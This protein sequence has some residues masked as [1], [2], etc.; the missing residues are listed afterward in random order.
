MA[1]DFSTIKAITIPEGTVKKI[2]SGTTVLWQLAKTLSSIA[3]SG[4][5]TSLARGSSFSFGGTVTATY[6]DGSTANV[7]SSSTFS[8]YNMNTAGTYTVTVSYTYEGVTK[9]KTYSLTV[10]KAWT[11]IY[12]GTYTKTLNSSSGRPTENI[13]TGVNLNTSNTLRISCQITTTIYNPQSTIK[14]YTNGT[15]TTTS[16]TSATPVNVTNKEFV[17]TKG[18][19]S[20]QDI[21]YWSCNRKNYNDKIELY[22]QYGTSNNGNIR[23]NVVSNSLGSYTATVKVTKIEQYY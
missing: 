14:W 4:Y 8:G 9:T 10:T 5:T 18:S 11:A 7:T 21:L 22:I 12:S 16:S 19:S 2:Q 3:I 13:K 6:S 15:A 1:I 23:L 17:L 20:Y